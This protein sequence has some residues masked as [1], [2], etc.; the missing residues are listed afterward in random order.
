MFTELIFLI[1][2]LLVVSFAPEF[3]LEPW[4]FTHPASF[5]MGLA[6]FVFLLASMGMRNKILGPA[7]RLSFLSHL[8]ILIFMVMFNFLFAPHLYF[9]PSLSTPNVLLSLT[10]YF[11]GLWVAHA[12]N[13]SSTFS[14][15]H[16]ACLKIR[17]ILP[18]V[19]PFLFFE[20]LTDFVAIDKM[21]GAIMIIFPFLFL[22]A[23]MFFFPPLLQKMWGCTSLPDSPLKQRLL[24][25]CRKANFQ[26]RDMKIWHVMKHALTA[27]IIGISPKTRYVMFTESLLKRFPDDEVEA[28]LAHEIG[29]SHHKH[30]LLYP[31]ILFG[32]FVVSTLFTFCL[33]ESIAD[34]LGFHALRYPSPLWGVVSPL[35]IFLPHALII[36]LYFRFAFGFFSRNFERQA[37]LHVYRV[38]IDPTHLINALNRVAVISG[39]SHKESSWHHYSIPDRVQFL[40]N[41]ADDPSRI[42]KHHKRVNRILRGYFFTLL[43]TVVLIA[44]ALFLN[45]NVGNTLSAVVNAPIK[46]SLAEHV[47][48]TYQLP[49]NRAIIA[50]TLDDVMQDHDASAIPGVLEFF[51]ALN[52]VEEQQYE[53]SVILMV[54]AWERF[55][56][57]YFDEEILAD[58]VNVTSYIY[59]NASEHNVDNEKY[60]EYLYNK[61]I[62]FGE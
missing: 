19:L 39:H 23:I 52:L 41:A 46:R 61:I 51:S 44:A 17:F 11:S 59:Y 56:F 5:F 6:L 57:S 12:T 33:G 35:A 48:S 26:C 50:S 38:G 3:T 62:E 22:A 32:M 10:M 30:L 7:R 43:F 58:F 45:I 18:F 37:D 1:L 24:A 28:I 36:F 40:E 13:N 16:Y 4:P 29:H 55:N 34:A 53:A 15:P 21:G 27:A 60:M 47:I 8:E 31:F 42:D 20:L 54:N 49:G 14:A 9:F 25:L 2:L